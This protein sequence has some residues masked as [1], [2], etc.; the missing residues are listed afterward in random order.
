MR[1]WCFFSYARDDLDKRLGQFFDD[2]EQAI[3]GREYLDPA[4]GE[5]HAFV[6]RKNLQLMTTWTH[7]LRDA[8]QR[9][10]TFACMVSPAYVNKAF[11]GKEY[12]I[13]DRRRRQN[14]AAGAK[15]PPVILPVIWIPVRGGLPQAIAESQFDHG[16]LPEEYKAEGLLYLM[17]MRRTGQYN[18][19][20]ETFAK[21]IQA[22]GLAHPAIP[23]FPFVNDFEEVPSAFEAT[24]PYR[25][26]FVFVAGKRAE[27]EGLP[28]QDRYSSS[29]SCY[30]KPFNPPVIET[31]GE[32]A[33]TIAS[34]AKV[35]YEELPADGALLNRIYASTRNDR[36]IVVAD[37]WTLTR[38]EYRDLLKPVD[39][40]KDPPSVVFA[41]LNCPGQLSDSERL[42]LDQAIADTFPQ[43]TAENNPDLLRKPVSSAADLRAGIARA[44]AAAHLKEVSAAAE[45]MPATADLPVISANPG[46][47]P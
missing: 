14:L 11:C 2:L 4:G 31:I 45:R 37:P 8:L 28:I 17:K 36:V 43:R 30:W 23:E 24:G 19:C 20:V 9:S 35:G 21:A 26:K 16:D 34:E 39:S 15:P 12:W 27:F 41:P 25:A 10:R 6:D 32:M 7:D 22:A 42:Q 38:P 46:A 5:R 18:K 13:F 29:R 47:K 44:L 33:E 3:R 40:I 1:Y